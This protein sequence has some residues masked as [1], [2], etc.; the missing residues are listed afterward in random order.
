LSWSNRYRLP[1]DRLDL[2]KIEA[3]MRHVVASLSPRKTEL[4]V[5]GLDHI[6]CAFEVSPADE[7]RWDIFCDADKRF[8]RYE[9]TDSDRGWVEVEFV[10]LPAD[11]EHDY[12]SWTGFEFNSPG[13]N[14]FASCGIEITELF[15]KFFGVECEEL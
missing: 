14:P 1:W 9:I 8:A 13:D 15:G 4:V 6:I 10:H 11:E 12:E 5:R 7:R 3:A 2:E